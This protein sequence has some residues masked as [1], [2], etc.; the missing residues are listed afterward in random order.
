MNIYLL[1]LAASFLLFVSGCIIINVG[2]R[3]GL[4]EIAYFVAGITIVFALILAFRRIGLLF[5]VQF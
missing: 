2:L 3:E 1:V 4:R 5:G